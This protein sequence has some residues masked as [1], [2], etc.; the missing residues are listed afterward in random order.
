MI[1]HFLQGTIDEDGWHMDSNAS[2]HMTRSDEFFKTLAE[3]DSKFHMVL[4]D[5]S[6]LA[7][8]EQVQVQVKVQA[9]EAQ[10]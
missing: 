2:K 7:M 5:K 8:Q 4:G 3:W 10:V 6:Q 9:S 1:S